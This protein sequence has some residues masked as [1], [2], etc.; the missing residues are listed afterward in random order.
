M[1][2]VLLKGLGTGVILQLAIGPIFLY[3]IN[4]VLQKDIINAFAAIAAVTIVDLLYISLAIV[5]IGKLLEQRKVKRVLG[6][7]SAVVLILFGLYMIK[8]SLFSPTNN[9]TFFVESSLSASF[10]STFVL[11]IASPLTIIFWT[12][13]FAA[14]ALELSL[15]TKELLGFGIAAGSATPLFLSSAVIIINQVKSSI[16]AVIFQLANIF[17]GLILIIYGIKRIYN[18]TQQVKIKREQ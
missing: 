5:G 10:L 14:K 2:K 15:T 11:T 16:P 4:I 17:V 13:V 12:S 6:I 7:V 9:N 8:S 1:K 18:S 3:I